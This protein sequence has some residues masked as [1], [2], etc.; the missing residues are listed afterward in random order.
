MKVSDFKKITVEE[1]K[2]LICMIKISKMED[3]LSQRKI[4]IYAALNSSKYSQSMLR[5][6]KIKIMFEGTKQN[7][8][9]LL[10]FPNS[11]IDYTY[12]ILQALAEIFCRK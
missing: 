5:E 12:S 2:I 8:K 6:I 4:F 11:L 1:A 7:V 10:C 9:S 3:Y